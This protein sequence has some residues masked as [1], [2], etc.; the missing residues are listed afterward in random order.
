MKGTRG[1]SQG[2]A[3]TTR[4]LARLS[5]QG[6]ARLKRFRIERSE[7]FVENDHLGLLQQRRTISKLKANGTVNTWFS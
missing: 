6:S 7:A 3:M 5:M 2:W 1:P 4:V